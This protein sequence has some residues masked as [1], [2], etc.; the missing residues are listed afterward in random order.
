YDISPIPYPASNAHMRLYKQLR[1]ASLQIDPH[2]FGS[3]YERESQFDESTWRARIDK[4]DR[5]TF[6]AHTMNHDDSNGEMMVSCQAWV[7][8]IMIL[9]P[10]ML[11]DFNL[12]L[13]R[14]IREE[15]LSVY[16]V[17]GMW[18]HP[19]HRNRSLGKRLV[20][21]SLEWAKD[22]K[23]KDTEAPKKVLLLEVKQDNHAAIALY[24]KLGF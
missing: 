6:I 23:E 10:E 4:P 7:G 19:N 17:V 2:A 18:V 3:S 13:P 21:S 1:L 16:V 24:A 14:S 9:S 22:S 11:H 8:S 5:I 20:L 15:G 12:P